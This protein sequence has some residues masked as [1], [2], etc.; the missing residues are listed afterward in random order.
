MR[1]VSRM[2]RLDHVKVF[3]FHMLP[4]RW[5]LWIVPPICGAIWVVT[6]AQNFGDT[7]DALLWFAAI[8]VGMF[9]VLVAFTTILY[10][11]RIWRLP[12]DSPA[13]SDAEIELDDTGIAFVGRGSRTTLEWTSITELKDFR[14]FIGVRHLGRSGN[15][16]LLPRRCVS[17]EAAAEIRRL[18]EASRADAD[19]R[20]PATV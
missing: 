7:T 10:A 19:P 1:F 11:F 16:Y 14:E 6:N 12:A 20:K 5:I 2:T 17:D 13:L 18:F 9:L 8:S 3:A 4:D 15:L